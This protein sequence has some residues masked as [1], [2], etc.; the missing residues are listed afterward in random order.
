MDRKQI[1]EA[2]HELADSANRLGSM[3]F[4]ERATSMEID[5]AMA[6]HCDDHAAVVV[7]I[8]ALPQEGI[9]GA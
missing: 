6:K 5:A 8:R 3:V 9:G 7:A 2:L 1:M 4:L